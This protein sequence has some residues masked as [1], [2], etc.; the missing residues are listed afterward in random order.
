MKT[1][2]RPW[3]FVF[4]SLFFL[5]QRKCRYD[6][7]RNEVVVLTSGNLVVSTAVYA[8]VRKMTKLRVLR[9]I[10][11]DLGRNPECARNCAIF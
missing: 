8:D 2:R 6:D 10:L 7:A 3:V 11:P 5:L 1:C 4:F 9:E